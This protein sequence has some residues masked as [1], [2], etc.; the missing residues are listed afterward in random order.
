[1]NG[2]LPLKVAW[3]MFWYLACMMSAGTTRG[4][5]RQQVEASAA[6]LSLSEKD[7][8][9]FWDGAGLSTEEQQERLEAMKYW[10]YESDMKASG[11][12]LHVA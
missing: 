7:Q 3:I 1:M 4:G 10:D 5:C 2:M 11:F 6:F 9:A 12:N 8:K